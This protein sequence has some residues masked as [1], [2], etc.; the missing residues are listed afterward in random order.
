MQPRD[1]RSALA[2]YNALT[3][4]VIGAAIE[5]HKAL[6]PGY[7]EAVYENA[8]CHELTLRQIEFE[9]QYR[10]NLIYKGEQVGEGRVDVLVE[11]ELVVELKSV[12]A[13]APIH[14]SQTLSYL[15]AL[16]LP[17]GL[18]INFNVPILVKGLHRVI[19]T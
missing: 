19:L 16:D 12:D 8:L 4:K 14:H 10:F 3:E 15:K 9:R 18:L 11:Q 7:L 2:S 6:G 17:L 13:I 1:R 5:V